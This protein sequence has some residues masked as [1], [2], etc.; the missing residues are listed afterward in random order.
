MSSHQIQQQQQQQQP[1]Q[2]Y[3]WARGTLFQTCCSMYGKFEMQNSKLGAPITITVKSIHT[4]M[5][6]K[7]KR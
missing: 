4:N 5:V 6:T 1:K 2:Q 7:I 3:S